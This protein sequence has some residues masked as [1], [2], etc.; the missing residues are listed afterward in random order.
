MHFLRG[1][2]AGPAHTAHHDNCR[3][4]LAPAALPRG[5]HRHVTEDAAAPMYRV[6]ARTTRDTT[7]YQSERRHGTLGS[8]QVQADALAKC[9]RPHSCGWHCGEWR[10]VEAVTGET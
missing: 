1:E 3:V 8:A 2:S 4:V 7:P 10:Q 9:V 5:T 6:S